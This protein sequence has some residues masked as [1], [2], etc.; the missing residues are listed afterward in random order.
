MDFPTVMESESDSL[1][2]F[3]NKLKLKGSLIMTHGDRTWDPPVE[4]LIGNWIMAY[5]NDLLALV[6]VCENE[7]IS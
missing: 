5:N 2:L 7:K 1:I 6:I 4:V 3:L